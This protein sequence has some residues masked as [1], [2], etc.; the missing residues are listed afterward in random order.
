MSN[1]G[2][3][4]REPAPALAL[5]QDCIPANDTARSLWLAYSSELELSLIQAARHE[6]PRTELRRRILQACGL[7]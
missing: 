5:H 2:H 6:R 3:P 1:R 7:Q 4:T